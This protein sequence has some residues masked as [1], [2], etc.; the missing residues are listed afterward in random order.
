MVTS[1]KRPAPNVFL[2]TCRSRQ[3]LRLIAD[4]WTALVIHALEGG[5]R[6]FSELLAQIDGISRK[7]LTQTLRDLERNGLVQRVVY[8]VVPPWVEYSLTPLGKS[9]LEPIKALS[10]WAEAH[11]DEVAQARSEHDQNP[12]V[13]V[14]EYT[15]SLVAQ[16]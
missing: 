4:Q 12:P 1:S 15:A 14:Q 7:M 9:L 2:A 11:M 6:R 13:S 5:T 10:T 3:V 16:R 8:P